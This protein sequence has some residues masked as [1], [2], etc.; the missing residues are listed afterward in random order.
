MSEFLK[1]LQASVAQVLAQ[2]DIGQEPT[3]LFEQAC[4]LGWSLI[5]L[6]ESHGGLGTGPAGLGVLARELGKRVVAAPILESALV[7]SLLGQASAQDWSDLIES[8]A[9]GAGVAVPYASSGLR[10]DRDTDTLSGNI[11]A[12]NSVMESGSS[13][14]WTEDRGLIAL[15]SA[16]TTGLRR[17]ERDAWDSTRQ[18]Y[19]L[20]FHRVEV[21]YLQV[22]ARDADAERLISMFEALRDLAFAADSLGGAEAL[23]ELTLEHLKVRT[24]FGRPL[25]M[26]QALK[27]R[28]AHLKTRVAS[29]EALLAEVL[30]QV[31]DFGSLQDRAV[32]IAQ[33]K[34]YV[35]RV[36]AEVAEDALQLHGGV[37]MA[38][39]HV[40]HLFLKRAMLNQNLGRSFDWYERKSAQ[41]L[42]AQGGQ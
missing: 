40:C 22:L 9:A 8:F 33:L 16:T 14:I 2:H 30:S 24:Q 12:V 41:Q 13:L 21:K 4:E 35:S 20:D 1:E 27:H 17:G 37:G 31:D 6:P 28:C 11:L 10:L 42:L 39:E 38:A 26:F 7:V 23:L 19:D 29:A 5:A 15:L 25:A 36:Y 18:L 32:A 34:H 3:D